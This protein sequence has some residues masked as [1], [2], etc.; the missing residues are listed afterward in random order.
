M[1]LG[2][3]LSIAGGV[4]LALHSA[5]EYGFNTVAMFVRSNVQWRAAKLTGETVA[6]F[7]R[8]RRRLG[9]GPVIAHGMYLANLA[10]RAAIRRKS[11]TAVRDELD[12][13][14]RLGIE[15]LVIHPGSREDAGFGIGLIA[16][17][18]NQII[19]DCPHR[20]PKVLLETTAGSGNSIGRTFEQLGEILAAV[21]YP[22]RVGI[23]MDT[24]H[25]FAAGYD[26]RGPRAY[27]RTMS[28]FDMVIGLSR[29]R[30]IHVSDSQKP[31]G[32]GVDRHA[33]IGLGLIGLGGFANLVND[34]RL[35]DTPLILETP[36]GCG[37]IG[38]G[39]GKA[40]KDWDE[41]NADVLR[42]LV[43]RRR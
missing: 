34:P 25:V 41:M 26:I 11:I 13:C 36:K 38:K 37:P 15:Y 5:A 27:R 42:S 16:G 24:C 29:L 22:R 33:H 19:A 39:K 9:I 20:R 3:H 12:R 7:R 23:C 21:R 17:A 35:T 31:L 1:L 40:G 8:T 28:R 6:R 43:G 2:A 32:S 18:L 30:A 14:G 4:D 10:G